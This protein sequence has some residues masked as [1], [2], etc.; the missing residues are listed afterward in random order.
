MHTVQS[1]KNDCF[2]LLLMDVCCR[3][4]VGQ[5]KHNTGLQ[6][7]VYA[8]KCKLSFIIA[9]RWRQ[10]LMG[11]SVQQ[12]I[13]Q[14]QLAIVKLNEQIFVTKNCKNQGLA[15]KNTLEK[16]STLVIRWY[17]RV[18]ENRIE[19]I[20][21]GKNCHSFQKLLKCRGK[22]SGFRYYQQPL[23]LAKQKH[24]ADKFQHFTLQLQP[25]RDLIQCKNS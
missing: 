14:L 22:T 13:V 5:V 12:L 24:S 11:H 23:V 17:D 25:V 19:N 10:A 2:L 7:A 1:P 21:L 18:K 8:Q 6:L 20:P 4:S 9:E 15:R 16:I 3:K